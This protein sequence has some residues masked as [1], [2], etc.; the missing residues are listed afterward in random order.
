MMRIA[1]Q[2]NP[3][4]MIDIVGDTTFA[5]CLEAQRRGY[6]VFYY[7]PDRILMRDGRIFAWIERLQVRDQMDHYY[8]LEESLEVELSEMDVIL[9]RQDPPFNMNYMT[10][11]YM[12]ERIHPRTF[13]VNNPVQVRDSPE[14]IFVTEFPDLMP[15]TLITQDIGEFNAFRQEFGDVILKPLYAHGGSGIFYL[16]AD[17]LNSLSL[18]DL[19]R[20]LFKEPFIVQ[21]YLKDIGE[22]DKRIILLDG[23]PVGAINRIPNKGDVRSNM[24]VG[25]RVERADITKREYEICDRI[26]PSLKERG[27]ILTGIDVIGGYLTEI[28]VTSPT[29]IREIKR[30]DG[31]DIAV[32]FWDLIEA[33]V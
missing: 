26:G 18:L 13:V 12:L 30:F 5:L 22:G 31:V 9:L 20:K 21:R 25:G 16:A 6:E 2:M 33:K 23:E 29:G 11:T 14:K 19:F 4:S 7:T 1:V 27:L 8:T 17:D 10:T 24:H 15:E 28:N 32:L 3:I